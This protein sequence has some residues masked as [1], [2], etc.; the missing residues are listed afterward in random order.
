MDISNSISLHRL[1]RL[2]LN[3]G[4]FYH[5]LSAGGTNATIIACLL[6][7]ESRKPLP[8]TAFSSYHVVYLVLFHSSFLFTKLHELLATE[9]NGIAHRGELAHTKF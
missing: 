3:Q 5:Q 2:Q 4:C 1:K 6:Q 9:N 8:T 7:C